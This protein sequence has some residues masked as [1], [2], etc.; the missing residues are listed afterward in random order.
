MLINSYPGIW[1]LV[2]IWWLMAGKNCVPFV[3]HAPENSSENLWGCRF[4]IAWQIGFDNVGVRI[5]GHFRCP[6]MPDLQAAAPDLARIAAPGLL[7]NY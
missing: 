2:E 3:Q 6:R 4:F 7:T 5:G 1:P